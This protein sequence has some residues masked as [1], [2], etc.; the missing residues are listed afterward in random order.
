MQIHRLAGWIPALLVLLF[1]Y[2]GCSK[3]FDLDGWTHTLYNQPFPRS[4]APFFAIALPCIELATAA[5]LLA[6]RTRL[7]GLYSALTLL[8]IFSL[9]IA[10]ILL[11]VF[12]KVPCSCGGIFRHLTWGQ[13]LW[14]N[15]ALLILAATALRH[16]STY[17]YAKV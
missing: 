6:D 12:R 14:L 13:H 17:P 16:H 5:T 8:T 1:V 3:L 7:I 9:Y 2:T 11:N 4:L 10:A 15:L